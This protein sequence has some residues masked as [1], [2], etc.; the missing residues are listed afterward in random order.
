MTASFFHLCLEWSEILAMAAWKP[1]AAEHVGSTLAKERE[2]FLVG[3]QQ[4]V[5]FD[6][7]CS[8][9]RLHDRRGRAMK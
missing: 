4:F 2:G 6:A 9:R 1:G 7:V 5:R 8:Q 3:R